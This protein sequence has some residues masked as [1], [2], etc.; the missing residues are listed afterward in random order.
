MNWNKVSDMSRR[1][2]IKT[3][4]AAGV[5]ASSLYW[6]SQSGLAAAAEED[7]VP[8]VK[9]L[10]GTPEP[11]GDRREPIYDSIPRKEWERRWTTVD[12]RDKIG[13]QLNKRYNTDLIAPEFT[14]MNSNHTEFGVK[15]VYTKMVQ[16]GE[17]VRSPDV[18]FSDVKEEFEGNGKGE[19]A[20]GRYHAVREDIPIV[21][22]R[23]A[24]ENVGCSEEDLMDQITID[25][26]PAGVDMTAVN[27]ASGSLCAPFHRNNYGEGWIVSGHVVGGEFGG[28]SG[29]VVKQGEA[30]SEEKIGE[31]RDSQVNADIDWAYV[32]D[33]VA[34]KYTVEKV[35][36]ENDMASTDYEIGGI[37]NDDTLINKADTDE[38][39]YTQGEATSRLNN[40]LINVGGIGSSYVI[41]EHD[42]TNGDSGGI[43]FGVDDNDYYAYVAGVM[44][45]AVNEDNDGDSCN[46]DTKS[47][48]AET[49]ENKADGCFLT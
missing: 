49:V 29:T 25:G 45:S 7:E 42:T 31:V 28:A 1:K 11:A 40:T 47:T 16:N 4:S 6:G 41:S 39:F 10:H 35:A 8:Y 24:E 48:T 23:R 21:V 46:D 18:P 38:T 20:K 17:V 3:A 26:I 32:E 34:G 5:S 33:S 19:A 2:F 44:K 12:L 37:V 9:F 30:G 15:V 13:R 36:Q 43:L 14:L 27:E 22:T